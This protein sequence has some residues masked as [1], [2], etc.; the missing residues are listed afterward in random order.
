MSIYKKYTKNRNPTKRDGPLHTI[1]NLINIKDSY[2]TPK[3]KEQDT[4]L[5]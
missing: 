3:D 1:L 5:S 2:G 4:T